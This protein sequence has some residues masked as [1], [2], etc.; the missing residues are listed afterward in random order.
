MKKRILFFVSSILF[1][2]AAH[3]GSF[4][5]CSVVTIVTSGDQNIHVFFNCT[6][7]FIDPPA[8]A[9]AASYVGF[10]GSTPAGKHYFSLLSLALALNLKVDGAI[11]STCSP[12][13]NNVALLISLRATKQ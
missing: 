12:Y 2:F 9:T 5:G 10:D 6:A 4:S 3:A 1:S 13:Q 8:C 7:P 11:D